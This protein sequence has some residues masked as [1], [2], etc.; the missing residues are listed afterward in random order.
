MAEPGPESDASPA[1][2]RAVGRRWSDPRLAVGV[3]VIAL[4]GFLGARLLA[5]ADDTVAVWAAR[6][7]LQAG[8]RLGPGD[9]VRRQV[10]FEDQTD[11]DRYLSADTTLPVAVTLDRAVGARELVPRAALGRAAAGPL[12]EVPLSVGADAV[13]ATVR[14]GSTVDVWVTRRGASA[15][16]ASLVFDDVRVLDAPAVGSSLGPA[17]TRQVIVGVGDDQ[18][19]GLPRS[20]ASLAAGDVILTGRR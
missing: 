12:T 7:P 17:A 9:L 20:L 19:P 4:C 5:R 16:P 8:Q 2:R 3:A 18:S 14:V 15:G 1:A 13:P 10:R 6:H 11:A